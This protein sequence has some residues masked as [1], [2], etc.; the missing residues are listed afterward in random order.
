MKEQASDQ[1]QVED[2]WDP[3]DSTQAELLTPEALQ[4]RQQPFPRPS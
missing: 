2:V 3:R 4:F 1:E